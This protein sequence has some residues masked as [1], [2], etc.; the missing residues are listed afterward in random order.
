MNNLKELC[1]YNNHIGEEGAK[2]I[3]NSDNNIGDRGV[4]FIA[5]SEILT[6]LIELCLNGSNVTHFGALLIASSECMQNL[7]RLELSSN[8]IDATIATAAI[9][10]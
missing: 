9:T 2:Y 5:T 1:L 8:N 6:R 4:Q 7:T 3:S 10:E